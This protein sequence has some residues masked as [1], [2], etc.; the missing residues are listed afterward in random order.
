[1]I[2]TR[3]FDFYA[4]AIRISGGSIMQIIEKSSSRNSEIYIYTF[5]KFQI[6]NIDYKERQFHSSSD[7]QCKLFEFMLLNSNRSISVDKII[8]NVYPD[9]SYSNVK[10]TLQNNI[11]R[12]R[13]AL[14]ECRVFDI[15]KKSILYDLGGYTLKIDERFN[16]DYICFENDI[17]KGCSCREGREE[18]ITCLENAFDIYKGDFMP[19]LD[20]EDWAIFKRNH[21]NRLYIKC[22]KELSNRYFEQER[23]DDAIKISE[24]ALNYEPYEEEIHIKLIEALVKKGSFRA[25]KKHYSYVTSMF[26]EEFNISPSEGM[27]L[28]YRDLKEI[29]RT[30][31]KGKNKKYEE[32]TDKD[33]K[34]HYCSC[35]DLALVY[36]IER[37][38]EGRT[39]KKNIPVLFS[40]SGDYDKIDKLKIKRIL[41]SSLREGDLVAKLDDRRY[42][43]YMIESEYEM[44]SKILE[45]II[46]RI[47]SNKELEKGVF[48][49]NKYFI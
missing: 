22:I 2:K 30:I 39:G 44:T 49:I 9:N 42:I 33:I 48:S 36:N 17:S 4:N 20:S 32:G 37:K 24:N 11:Y 18:S 38:R 47:K 45:R 3:Q 26:Y 28:A 41:L 21:F 23:Y 16:I 40:C 10:N 43:V 27:Q 35:D 5:G 1:M 19:N 8:E 7:K 29:S 12:L 15:P 34:A 25:A 6:H 14:K 13:K 46:R 31:G